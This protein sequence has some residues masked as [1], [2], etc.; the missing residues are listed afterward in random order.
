MH[1][2]GRS[3]TQPSTTH[4]TARSLRA[5]L[6]CIHIAFAAVPT[7]LHAQADP[8]SAAAAYSPYEQATIDEATARLESRVDPD[9]EGKVVEGVDVVTLDVI[10]RRDPA[11]GTTAGPTSRVPLMGACR[12]ATRGGGSPRRKIY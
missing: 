1:L 9:P 4:M 3:S 6:L 11:P 8:T 7:A 12:I 2:G 10:E 5:A